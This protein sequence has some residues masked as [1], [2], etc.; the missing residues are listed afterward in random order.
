MTHMINIQPRKPRFDLSDVPVFW[1]DG[2]PVLTRFFDALSIHFPDGER[3]FIQSVRN[4]QDLVTD[5]KLRE[6]I[7]NF[8][9]QEAQHGIVHDQYN[10]VMQSQGIQAEKVIA[11]FKLFI[12]LSQKHLPAK[13]LLAMTAAFEHI[14]A[15][16]GEG[17]MEG[18]GEMF[19]NAHPAMRAMFMWHGVEEVEH[20]TVAF[21]VYETAAG[22]GYF[23]RASAL[24]IGTLLVHAVVGSVLWHMLKIDKLQGQPLVLAKGFYRLYGPR[25]LI[26]RLIPRYLDWFKPGFHPSDTE[27]PEKVNSWLAEYDKHQDPMEAS[28]IVFN[29]PIAK[30]V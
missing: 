22:G 17:A 29:V 1:N 12:R 19:K 25:G 20:K 6:D 24:I 27:I 7:K 23:T 8:F 21:D 30:A 28:R 16:L 10:A 18:E 26:T 13:Y 9:R 14:T 5:P 2:D 11:R 3:F 15:V 4:Y